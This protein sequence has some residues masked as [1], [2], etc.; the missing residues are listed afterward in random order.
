MTRV[1]RTYVALGDSF[2]CG[3]DPAVV[4]WAELVAAGLGRRVRYVNLARV[5]ATSVDVEQHQV[6]EA[7]RARPDLVSVVCGANDLLE[8][9]HPDPTAYA[10][11]LGRIIDRLAPATVLTGTYP[12]FARFLGLRPRTRLRVEE[13]LRLF[14]AAVREV[15]AERGALL[16]EGFDHP[17]AVSRGSFADDGL[18]PS[19]AGHRRSAAAVLGVVNAWMRT[20][21]E[22]V[23]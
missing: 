23:V 10:L 6:P 5:G 19:P 2:T 13:G 3:H 9:L 22:M 18:H 16:V 17:G 20:Q 21:E 7:L 1:P 4:P 14:N 12:P 15:A 11:R 8:C